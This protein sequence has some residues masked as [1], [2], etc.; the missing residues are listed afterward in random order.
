[1]MTRLFSNIFVTLFVTTFYYKQEIKKQI[2]IIELID[3][4]NN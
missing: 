2:N 4:L 3:Y 1:M